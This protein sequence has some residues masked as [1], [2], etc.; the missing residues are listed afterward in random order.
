MP[1]GR[2]VSYGRGVKG[3]RKHP[4]VVD[5]VIAAVFVAAAELEAALG[6]TTR[7]AW[8]HALLAPVFLAPLVVRRRV[9]LL[10]FASAVIGLLV[11]DAVA[12]LS[13]FGA[14]VLAS[15]SAGEALSGRQTY[16]VP[17][18]AAAAFAAIAVDGE[19]VPSDFVAFALFLVGPWWVGRLVR[20]RTRQ[21]DAL[22]R[23]AEL[24]R[25][26]ETAAA[27][28]EERARIARELH[29][30]ISHAISVVTVQTQAV[31]LRLTPEHAR[32]ADDLRGVEA[33]ARQAMAEMR[34]LFGVLRVDGA[35]ASL[36]PQPG[37]DQLDRLVSQ[38]RGSGLQLDVEIEGERVPL[39]PGVDLAAYRIVQEALTNVVRHAGSAPARVRLDY[40]DSVLAVTVEDDGPGRARASGRG[41]GLLG[42][43]ERVALYGGTLET[44]SANGGGFRVHARLPFREAP[45]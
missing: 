22:V 42:M 35:P 18:T 4:L 38:V 30:I 45:S 9:P 14:V 15:Y 1:L 10:A 13:L 12:A 24:E 8:L 5:F 40:G 21:A 41:H 43:R 19:A 3:L 44:G 16:L 26:R 29:D 25:D 37:L 23:L 20:Q 2:G 34:R 28:Q 27:V 17:A 7:D 39:P 32:E 11:L 31:R 36:A 33:T 6:L